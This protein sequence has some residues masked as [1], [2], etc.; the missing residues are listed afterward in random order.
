MSGPRPRGNKSQRPETP[1]AC[2]Q[3]WIRPWPNKRWRPCP[4]E[5]TSPRR[6]EVGRRY[7]RRPPGRRP[8]EGRGDGGRGFPVSD[9]LASAFSALG[10]ARPPPAGIRAGVALLREARPP[11]AASGSLKLTCLRDRATAVCRSNAPSA[12]P[13]TA[14]GPG[15]PGPASIPLGCPI[16]RGLRYRWGVATG[17]CE[18]GGA[19]R[20]WG[21]ASAG[22]AL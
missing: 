12:E 17:R 5:A 21:G 18:T 1:H 10:K 9:H 2:F 3:R 6:L 4:G 14:V 13:R 11:E 20:A 22:P 7:P 15:R 19:K 16:E 8:E